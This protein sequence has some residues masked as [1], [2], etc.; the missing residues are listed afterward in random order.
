MGV[1]SNWKTAKICKLSHTEM[2]NIGF[3]D[4]SEN[5][6]MF[7]K[8]DNYLNITFVF[9]MNKDFPKNKKINVKIIDGETKKS[10]PITNLD[11]SP[12][13]NDP[14][15]YNFLKELYLDFCEK[16]FLKEAKQ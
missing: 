2:R 15:I 4:I 16:G 11:N 12:F 5:K 7:Y 13:K 8:S 14:R 9:I 6:W 10:Y 3:W 1:I